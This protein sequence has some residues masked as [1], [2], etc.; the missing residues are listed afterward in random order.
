MSVY[1]FI[2]QVTVQWKLVN[3]E[4]NG[5]LEMNEKEDVLQ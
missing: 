4:E 1:N 2:F 3:V 5:W